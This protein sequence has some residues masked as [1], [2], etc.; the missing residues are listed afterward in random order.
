MGELADFLVWLQ[1]RQKEGKVSIKIVQVV[2]Y[3]AFEYLVSL[4]K[5]PQF[6]KPKR[7]TT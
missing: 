4:G 7:S 2:G 1:R 3:A 5:E 6:P